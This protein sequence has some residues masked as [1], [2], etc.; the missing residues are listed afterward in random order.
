MRILYCYGFPF[1]ITV[2]VSRTIY[3]YHMYVT[4][5]LF[6]MTFQKTMTSHHE[7][8]QNLSKFGACVPP[9]GTVLSSVIVHTIHTPSE[10]V[11]L[12]CFWTYPS[13]HP[14]SFVRCRAKL[15]RTT[16]ATAILVLLFLLIP[17]YIRPLH[18]NKLNSSHTHSKPAVPFSW[19]EDGVESWGESCVVRQS[20]PQ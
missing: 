9:G 10:D 6:A 3:R 16:T 11:Q 18:E 8:R 14:L 15:Y 2:V 7:E 4:D 20:E 5:L 19:R 1:S 12:S 17:T 13:I